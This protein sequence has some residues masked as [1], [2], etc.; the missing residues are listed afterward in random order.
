MTRT[1]RREFLCRAV[2]AA[3]LAAGLP[4]IAIAR[5]L[6]KCPFCAFDNEDGALFC[7]QCKSD[8]SE[9]IPLPPPPPPTPIPIPKVG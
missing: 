7:E 3:G 9:G 8:L 2:A 4:A 6:V 1:S 5:P